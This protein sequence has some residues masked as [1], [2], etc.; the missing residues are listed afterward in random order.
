MV[1]MAR[2]QIDPWGVR[3]IQTIPGYEAAFEKKLQAFSIQINDPL[4]PYMSLKDKHQ[5]LLSRIASPYYN[6]FYAGRIWAVDTEVTAWRAQNKAQ[7]K[8]SVI[9]LPGAGFDA[10]AQRY[11]Q[12]DDLLIVEFDMP[13]TQQIKRQ[14]LQAIQTEKKNVLYYPVDYTNPEDGKRQFQNAME[15]VQKR[16]PQ[17]DLAFFVSLEGLSYYLTPEANQ[18]LFTELLT[19]LPP[20]TKIFTDWIQGTNWDASTHP[21]AQFL[22]FL[23]EPLK[24]MPEDFEKQITAGLK[25]EGKII[26]EQSRINRAEVAAD[27]LEQTIGRTCPWIK[28]DP[29]GQIVQFSVFEII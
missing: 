6:T 28:A 10:K 2:E 11:P 22:T 23:E 1:A 5:R 14:A 21:Y 17:D 29:F 12:S 19:I 8:K 9:F 24:T 25:A 18:T 20:G 7:G 27:R 3:M 16:F 4:M 13:H 15:A 26:R